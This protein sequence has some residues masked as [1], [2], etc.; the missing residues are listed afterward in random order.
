MVDSYIAGAETGCNGSDGDMIEVADGL[1]VISSMGIYD[2]HTPYAPQQIG[3]LTA[4]VLCCGYTGAGPT[5]SSVGVV[6]SRS[7]ISLP[8]RS[9][10]W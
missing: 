9:H 8:R 10:V 4:Q 3:L 6:R 2:V 1:A 5:R 7:W